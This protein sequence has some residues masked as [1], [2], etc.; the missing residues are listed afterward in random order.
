L[1]GLDDDGALLVQDD[2]GTTHRAR[3]GD[4]ELESA[5]C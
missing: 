3:S 1:I 5:S 2:D 4:V